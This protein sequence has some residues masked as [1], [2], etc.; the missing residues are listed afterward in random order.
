[1]KRTL[2]LLLLLAM[3]ASALS[4]FACSGPAG[5]GGGG[6]DIEGVEFIDHLDEYGD[7]L[8]FS[9]CE[10]FIISYPEH[11]YY[12]I[13]GEESSNEKLDTLVYN[14][15]RLLE[16]RFGVTIATEHGIPDTNG[17]GHYDYV[18]LCMNSGDVPFDVASMNAYQAGKL[19]FGGSSGNLLDFRSEVPY[20]KDSILRGEEWWP[21]TI[22]LASTV[23]GRQFVAVSDFSITA[24]EMAFAVIFN[25]N[26]AKSTNVVQGIDP[27]KY[28]TDSTLYDAVRN[29]DWTLDIFTSLVKDFW[30][31]NPASGKR[32]MR[33][34]EDRFGMVAPAWTDADAF[35]YAFGYNFII[36]DGV[37][38]PELWDW[39]GSQYD[40]LVDLRELY[41]SNGAWTDTENQ[42]LGNRAAF[43][44]QEDHALFMLNTL[45]SLKYEVIHTMEQ[46][47]GVLP[48]PKYKREQAKY[49]TGSIDN[50]TALA[51]PYTAY[52]NEQRLRMTGALIE[53]LAAENCNSIKNP[54]YDEIVTHHNVT[55]GD[56]AEMINLIMEG[57]VYDLA[58]YHYNELSLTGTAFATMFRHLVRERDQDIVQFWQSNAGS[59]EI[60]LTD[61][62]NN[63][64][65]IV[66]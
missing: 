16:S 62:L 55:D 33:D 58:A 2:S 8:D 37:S 23:M 51:V 9:S 36:N 60:K 52:W 46:D 10:E 28:T 14:R 57:R 38:A 42:H 45:G 3:L 30:R 19:I 1:M 18:Q 63:Y 44:A 15:N 48:Y 29:N 35:A 56:S 17:T 5:G 11:F 64:A 6:G 24:I 25:K 20:V 49:L 43:F 27:T 13:Y 54:Y 26:L 39:D 32:G 59:L 40:A 7:S 47:F 12:E 31:D 50:Y 65:S 66:P 34:K 4:L 41:Y 53:A 61:L 22:N 21:K